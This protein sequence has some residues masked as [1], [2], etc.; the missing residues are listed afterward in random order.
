MKNPSQIPFDP[1]IPSAPG[2]A[3]GARVPILIVDDDP[4]KRL[5]L[6]AALE[7]LRHV[8]VEAESGLAALRCI[9]AQ[10]FAVIL[11][12]VCMPTMDGFETAS[13]IRQRRQSE[14]TPIIFITAYGPDEVA[15]DHYAQ[16]AV[17]FMFAPVDPATLRAK[18][19]VFANLFTRAE[20]LASQARDVQAS[21]DQL[22]L[23]T[24]AAPVGIFQTDE[25]GRYLYTNPR[26][27]EITGIE[28]DD[29]AGREW[30]VIVS[31]EDVEKVKA[32]VGARPTL[33]VDVNQRFKVERSGDAS[34]VV[35]VTAVAIR[36]S[37]GGTSGW[38]GTVADVTA[39]VEA[40]VVISAA[41]DAA[42]QAS[43]LKS[44]F[45]AN[46]SHEIRTPM[47][48]V[49][50]MTDLLLETDL[51]ARQ[52]DFAQTL[53]TS[54]EVLLS[55]INEILDFS[56]IEAGQLEIDNLDFELR[57]VVEDV[58]YLLGGSAQTKGIELV[59]SI[60]SAI[61]D[62]VH[63]DP[64][65]V[66]QI[67][68]NLIGN[69]IKFTQ[70]GE[71]VIRIS[72]TTVRGVLRFEVTDTGDGIAPDKLEQIFRP[73]VQADTSTSRK[74]GGTGLGLAI[75]SQLVE[76]MGGTYGVSSRTDVGST[77]WFTLSLLS[78]PFGACPGVQAISDLKGVRAL[79]VDDNDSHRSVL[80]D[81]LTAWGMNVTA[82][83]SGEAA[84]ATLQDAAL[85]DRAFSLALIDQSMPEEG[86]QV[87]LNAMK[88]D[89]ALATQVVLM[90][91]LGETANR[92]GPADGE[93]AAY[94]SKPIR[95]SD[96]LTSVRVALGMTIAPTSTPEPGGPSAA[97]SDA[98]ARGHLLL[99]EDNLINQKVAVA[100]LS[101]AG[102]RVDTV[103]DGGA[104]VRAVATGRYDAILMDCQ[105]PGMSGYEA[106]A[107]IRAWEAPDQHIPII[108]MTASARHE[109][110]ERCFAQGMDGYLA[111]P[112]SSAALLALMKSTLN[113]SR[114][115][116]FESSL[117][118]ESPAPGEVALDP[119]FLED[120]RLLRDPAGGRTLVDLVH[121][122]GSDTE[123][124][125]VQLHSA[126]DHGDTPAM[127]RIA[128]SIM[129]SSGQMGGRRLVRTC[130]RLERKAASGS[131]SEC[132]N[133]LDQVEIDFRELRDALMDECSRDARAFV[134]GREAI[135]A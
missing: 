74:Y 94:L 4:S 97:T 55:I 39:E 17:D 78:A 93:A 22:R 19:T 3:D 21:A 71:V 27:S 59:A 77:F 1:T 135:P 68:T 111:K 102:Y 76:L 98:P 32:E 83:V 122:F 11:I 120:L 132:H 114:S 123:L 40:E 45:L 115:S 58:V 9:L 56:K 53:R 14:M 105:M 54:G 43:R 63:G 85:E 91:G 10:D 25:D 109:D 117:A 33:Q 134:L 125:L 133:L 86:G 106:T 13:L 121:L 46:M 50:G 60:D 61:P 112:V 36:K 20:L 64:V 16:G 18:V 65:R 57:T 49:I 90:T 30:Y 75:C 127:G 88:R 73:F 126:F 8:V 26:W 52:R 104:A 108:A 119:S 38:V 87:L 34:R 81:S 28:A 37:T 128:H 47:N 29:A 15:P 69:A 100:I 101:N 99:A 103:L 84:W 79:V 51:D 107:A 66:R 12:D 70:V 24:D 129:G 62:V 67:L 41:R 89:P 7:P 113:A 124:R 96:L 116:P 2:I 48:G 44:D 42:T 35:L 95:R 80:V 110:R 131:M 31:A 72:E 118:N 23:L 92:R 130:D 82:A 5:A 6:R